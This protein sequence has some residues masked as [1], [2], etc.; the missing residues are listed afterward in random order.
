MI[1]PQLTPVWEGLL[2]IA[3]YCICRLNMSEW[4]KLFHMPK[5]NSQLPM[6]PRRKNAQP[7][8]QGNFLY[9]ALTF[10]PRARMIRSEKSKWS[11]KLVAVLLEEPK[12]WQVFDLPVPESN[13]KF[14]ISFQ[15]ARHSPKTESTLVTNNI[16]TMDSNGFNGSSANLHYKPRLEG[17]TRVFQCFP[18]PSSG[19]KGVHPWRAGG[20]GSCCGKNGVTSRDKTANSSGKK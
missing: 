19:P 5:R 14:W 9:Q 20:L 11:W 10:W 2:R 15:L 7:W 17:F 1:S 3:K 16:Q 4:T 18:P 12:V 13:W 8:V 6:Q